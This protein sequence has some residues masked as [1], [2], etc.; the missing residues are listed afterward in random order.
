M[1]KLSAVDDLHVLQL[2]YCVSLRV[3]IVLA[4]PKIIRSSTSMNTSTEELFGASILNYIGKTPSGFVAVL[5]VDVKHLPTRAVSALLAVELHDVHVPFRAGD[6]EGVRFGHEAHLRALVLALELRKAPLRIEVAVENL[7]ER[8]F[9][10]L[11]LRLLLVLTF[12]QLFTEG[13][14]RK[15]VHSTTV[16][17][18]GQPFFVV[19][20]RD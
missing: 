7:E 3:P 2:E 9:A 19:L 6:C 15:D 4:A 16:A 20:E 18:A 5:R 12:R 13:L 11:I 14:Q 17:A 10:L 8:Q 1:E